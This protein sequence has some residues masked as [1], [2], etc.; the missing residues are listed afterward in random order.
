MK[1]VKGTASFSSYFSLVSKNIK[2]PAST[3]GVTAST[4]KG[5]SQDRHNRHLSV[6]SALPAHGFHHEIFARRHVSKEKWTKG[7]LQFS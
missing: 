5:Y 6:G 1:G 7:K 4:N 3:R 2:G